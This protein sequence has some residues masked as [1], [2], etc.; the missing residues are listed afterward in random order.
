[1]PVLPKWLARDELAFC[2]VRR[3]RRHVLQVGQ[4]TVAG[5]VVVQLLDQRTVV[6]HY[7]ALEGAVH[8]QADVD[9]HA[10]PLDRAPDR[11]AQRLRPDRQRL[12][13]EGGAPG[14]HAEALAEQEQRQAVA[15]LGTPGDLVQ[16]RGFVQYQ[17]LDQTQFAKGASPFD[18]RIVLGRVLEGGQRGFQAEQETR[19]Q[20]GA[21][22]LDLAQCLE[23]TLLQLVVLCLFGELEQLLLEL[24][25]RRDQS[26]VELVGD[27][28]ENAFQQRTH[29]ARESALRERG[30][31]AARC[32]RMCCRT[33]HELEPL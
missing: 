26:A 31:W 32:A 14:Q 28:I 24:V 5:E 9:V 10:D 23:T 15:D 2:S 27:V 13:V 4:H 17:I 11:A 18:P 20:I 7:L 12:G 33:L 16:R 1:M 19:G 21:A 30:T 22:A 25:Q 3:A 29:S 8:Q 6:A